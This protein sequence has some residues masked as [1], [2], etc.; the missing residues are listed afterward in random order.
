MQTKHFCLTGNIWLAL[1]KIHPKK[2]SK[3]YSSSGLHSVHE[4]YFGVN[5]NFRVHAKLMKTLN[6]FILK[7]T[8]SILEFVMEKKASAYLEESFE[9]H[10]K[11]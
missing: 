11:Y 7:F 4:I 1:N 9:I 3:Y 6:I 10:T 8:L 2:G 5:H